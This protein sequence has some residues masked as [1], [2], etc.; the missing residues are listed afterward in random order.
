VAILE[1]LLPHP[2]SQQHHQSS[3]NNQFNELHYYL[4]FIEVHIIGKE[5]RLW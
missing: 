4:F 1:L 5:L 2:P 3:E